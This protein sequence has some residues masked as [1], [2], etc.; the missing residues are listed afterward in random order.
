MCLIMLSVLWEY[1]SSGMWPCIVGWVV[2]DAETAHIV[3][4]QITFLSFCH[5]RIWIL[6]YWYYGVWTIFH[7]ECSN[8]L[9]RNWILSLPV[10]QCMAMRLCCCSKLCI[11]RKYYVSLFIAASC[12]TAFVLFTLCV[13]V[14]ERERERERDK[15]E[16]FRWMCVT[17][18]T[19]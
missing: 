17:K 14:C 9:F 19:H 6:M 3:T 8:L 11:A 5:T 4:S 10:L 1:R 16:G 7:F 18:L 2:P 15:S 12:V 13:C